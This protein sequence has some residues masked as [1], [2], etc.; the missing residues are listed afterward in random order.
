MLAA[1]S[2]SVPIVQMLVEKLRARVYPVRRNN[3][4]E[5]AWDLASANNDSNIVQYLNSL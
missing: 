4:D 3:A 5:S 1:R 2:G